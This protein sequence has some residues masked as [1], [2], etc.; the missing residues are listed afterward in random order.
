MVLFFAE[1]CRF[2]AG[3]VLDHNDVIS[4]SAVSHYIDSSI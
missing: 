3:D 1:I 4:G 2:I